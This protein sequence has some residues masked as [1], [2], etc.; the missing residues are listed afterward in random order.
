[1]QEIHSTAII[2]KNVKLG[3]QLKIGA[4]VI[5]GNNVIIGENVSIKPFCEIRD[6]CKIGNNVSFGSR[7]TLAEDT[8]V[9]DDV[10]IKYGVVATNTPN[11]EKEKR[12]P[13]ELKEGSKFGANV[14]LMPG[15]TIGKNSEIGACSQVRHDVPNNE[16]WYGSPAKFFKKVN[17]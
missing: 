12:I 16:I 14:T 7:C 15:V 4:F 8:I 13:C 2:G 9:K 1:M 3:N 10:I 17:S 11:L 5:I 6:G